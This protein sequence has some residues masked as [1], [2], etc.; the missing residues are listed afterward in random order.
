MS[1][2]L[3]PD[4][5]L[6]F[7]TD[8]W[9]IRQA[10]ERL[11]ITARDS[12]ALEVTF[13]LFDLNKRAFLWQQL[14]FEESWWISAYQFTGS[15]VIFQTY[16]DTQD[17]ESRTAFAFDV[18]KEE[19]LW[20]IEE[21]KLQQVNNQVI[22]YTTEAGESALIEIATGALVDEAGV[23]DQLESGA[24]PL[25]YEA[26]SKH[27][28]TLNKFLQKKCGT[29]FVGG[30]DYLEYENFILISGNSREEDTYSLHLFVFDVEGNLLLQEIMEND[31]KGL[32]SGTFFI[33]NQALIFVKEKREIVFYQLK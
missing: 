2:Q 31:L 13:S 11:L 29:S 20:S 8:V 30:I 1:I 33:V 16:N 19:A 21:V 32:A 7:Q 22:R 3:E 6:P 18:A 27:C 14:A 28:E 15:F 5:S 26:E 17:I 12:E 24:F 23:S 4:F 9:E 10:G 25:H